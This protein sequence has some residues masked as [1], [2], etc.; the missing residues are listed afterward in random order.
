MYK[1]NGV[2]MIELIQ[3]I[4]RVFCSIIMT[5][6]ALVSSLGIT[7][8]IYS[9]TNTEMLLS[10]RIASIASPLIIT[11]VFSW[12]LFGLLLKISRLESEMRTLATYD[13]LTGFYNRNSFFMISENM[14]NLMNREKLLLTVFYIDI[15]HFK[16]VNDTYGHDVG[17]FV[18]QNIAEYIT[19]NVRQ[20][21]I[22]GRMGGEE[23]VVALPKTDLRDGEIVAE[24]LRKGIADLKLINKDE[25]SIKVTISIGISCNSY[26]ENI[27]I[28]DLLKKADSAL[29]HAKNRGRNKIYVSEAVKG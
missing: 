1:I 17:D 9:I 7:Y 22:V 5:L 10:G 19:K 12:W 2:S 27:S 11:P 6:F 3:K 15:D 29:Y 18:L 23:F 24:N 13:S 25:I 26:I 28:D 4:G 20:S 21:D 14:L 8:L 16:K